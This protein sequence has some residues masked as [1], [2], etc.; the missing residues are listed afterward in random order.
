METVMAVCSGSQ[1]NEKRIET[2][3]RL[4]GERHCGP[5]GGETKLTAEQHHRARPQRPSAAQ[6]IG[7]KRVLAAMDKYQNAVRL[8]MTEAPVIEFF[9]K[10]D[11][12]ELMAQMTKFLK[13][14][15][16]FTSL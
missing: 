11:A 4:H 10:R 9:G 5:L 2:R 1:E 16:T 6:H 12:A 13:F 8:N 3:R 15:L 14:A 7:D